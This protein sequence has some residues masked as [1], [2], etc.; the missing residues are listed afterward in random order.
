MNATEV[1]SNLSM[2]YM[3]PKHI[4]QE[5]GG[6]YV[7]EDITLHGYQPEEII[8]VLESQ[9]W[10]DISPPSENP[11]YEHI[12]GYAAELTG[13]DLI[14]HLHA[15]LSPT[16]LR[17][18]EHILQGDGNYTLSELVEMQIKDDHGY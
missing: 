11:M 13:P 10:R 16:K 17:E 7:I 4:E 1:A 3:S 14:L 8:D 6:K 12:D 15:D 18:V 2:S 9:D 5:N